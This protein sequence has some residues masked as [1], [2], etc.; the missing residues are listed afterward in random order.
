[1]MDIR[2]SIG[3]DSHRFAADGT[4]GKCILGGAVFED[5]PP[6]LAN[7]DGDVVLHAITNAISGITCR[8]ILGSI[9]DAMCRSGITDSREYLAVAMKDLSR[10]GFE[11]GNLSITIEGKRP[12]ISPMVEQM[13]QSISKL[14]GVGADRI[15]ITA[16]TG[17]G[18]TGF[19]RGE[20]VSVFCVLTARRVERIVKHSLSKVNLTLDVLSLRPDGYHDIRTL[21]QPVSLS[22]ELVVSRTEGDGIEFECSEPELAGDDNIICKA[23][24]L[25]KECYHD[26]GGCHVTLNKNVPSGAGL[27]GGSGDAAAMLEALN[28]LFGLRLSDAELMSV[29]AKLGADVPALI[30]KGASVGEGI[31]ERLI[32][33]KTRYLFHMVFIKPK[34][35]YPTGKMYHELDSVLG[36]GQQSDDDGIKQSV[37]KSDIT[38]GN[39]DAIVIDDL[40]DMAVAGLEKG[41]L[42]MICEAAFN[43]FELAVPDKEG[44]SLRKD[45]LIKTGAKTALMTGSGSC[46]Y[47]IFED[48]ESAKKAKAELEGCLPDGDLVFLGHTINQ[49]QEWS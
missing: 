11:V 17:E 30:L 4:I 24:R 36:F 44:L 8:N 25:M 22:D 9:A 18:L 3:Q 5:A 12:K 14:L 33:V 28:E 23:Y 16:T 49:W 46:V 42:D 47:G 1:M 20:G 26:I 45:L 10:A 41:N 40:T 39:T 6:F 19:G 43:V 32:A 35:A 21:F 27:G 13:R 38:D 34:E 15:G 37:G 29:G 31:G 7:S 48:Y 2:V